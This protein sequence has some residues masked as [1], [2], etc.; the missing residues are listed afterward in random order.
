MYISPRY[1][2]G[3]WRKLTFST[4]DEWQRAIDIFEDRIRGRFLNHISHIEGDTFAGFAV[5][6]LDCLLIETLQQFREGVPR[7]PKRQTKTF[8]VR[9]LTKTS[10]GSYFTNKKLAEMF[11]EQIRCGILHQAETGGNSK[12]RT[13][14]LAKPFKTHSLIEYTDDKKGLIINRKLFHQQLVR[15]FE[16]Y[17]A[18]LR[19]GSN[20]DLRNNFRQK[21]NHICGSP[22]EI[23]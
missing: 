4:D 20:Q 9:F 22:S 21:M 8:F 16:A 11:Y 12:V 15:E 14:L 1:T 19:R 10:F 5:L 6:A 13:W 2:D 7:T 17:V 3:D 18:T 23:S